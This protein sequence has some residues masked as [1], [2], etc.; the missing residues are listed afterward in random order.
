MPEHK[1]STHPTL[2]SYTFQKDN[3]CSIRYT[4]EKDSWGT[5]LDTTI[6]MTYILSTNN[7]LISLYKKES[8]NQSIISEQYRITGLKNN[9][10][11]WINALP[12][13]GS[14]DKKLTKE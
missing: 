5:P 7:D 3:N 8:G 12:G 6:Y 10:M 14:R 13:N 1:F 11:Q 9:E 2:V 4:G